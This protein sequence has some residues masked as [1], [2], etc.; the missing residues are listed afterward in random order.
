MDNYIELHDGHGPVLLISHL[1]LAVD[2]DRD[3]IGK[4]R[5]T[6][7]AARIQLMTFYVN[8]TVK[9]VKDLLIKAGASFTQSNFLQKEEK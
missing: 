6:Y 4:T 2:K 3:H 1:I 8:E 7:S 9:E 5:V